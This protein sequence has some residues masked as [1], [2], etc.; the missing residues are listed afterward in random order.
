MSSVPYRMP[1]RGTDRTPK[2]NGKPAQL[3]DFLETYDQYA[4]DANLQGLDRITQLLR[5]L[6]S[7][8][9]ELWS[10]LP[11]A[12]LSDYDAFTKEVKEM[13]PGWE[14]DR[15]YTV[16]NLQAVTAK[17]SKLPMTWRDELSEYIRAL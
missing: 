10:G 16:A 15:R 14:G 1:V 7:D 9:R 12:K 11:Q 8:D 2:F 13:Y 3:R 17:Y 6:S 4:D 5:Y